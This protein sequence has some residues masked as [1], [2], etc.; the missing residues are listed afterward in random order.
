MNIVAVLA[1]AILI[2]LAF[3]AYCLRDL[4]NTSE[5]RWM[6]KWGWA[7]LCVISIPVGGLIYLTLAKP[8]EG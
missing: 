1:P 4:S 6:P 7:I 2:A 8:N 3:V 5:V